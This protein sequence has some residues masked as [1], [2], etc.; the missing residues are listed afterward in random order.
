MIKQFGTPN[1][2]QNDHAYLYS[3]RFSHN[4]YQK[5]HQEMSLS[6]VFY[7]KFID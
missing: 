2:Q 7:I 5:Q 3:S 4:F 6:K 1:Q